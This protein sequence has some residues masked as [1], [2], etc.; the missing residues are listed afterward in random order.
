MSK[1]SSG[2]TVVCLGSGGFFPTETTQTACYMIPELGVVFDMGTGFPRVSQHLQTDRLDIFISHA[3]NDHVGGVPYTQ[4]LLEVTR[5]KKCVIHGDQTAIDGIKGLLTPPYFPSSPPVE[6]EIL[7]HENHLPNGA[8]IYSF[9]LVHRG[10]CNGF[11][12]YYNRYT[13]TYVTDTTTTPDSLYL[14]DVQGSNLLLHECYCSKDTVE[15]AQKCGHSDPDNLIEFCKAA[16]VHRLV[17][18]HHSP[19]QNP[20]EIA[21][22]IQEKL[23]ETIYAKDNL[24][25]HV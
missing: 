4:A 14:L 8:I 23:P 15:L 1:H 25:I 11:R 2:M 22:Y 17:T 20:E 12:L 3:H 5:C 7:K 21:N 24:V 9:P 16:N 18:I 6:Y 10:P 19:F 13:V